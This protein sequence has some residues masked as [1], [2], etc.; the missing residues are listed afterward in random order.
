[1]W[2]MKGHEIYIVTDANQEN[3]SELDFQNTRCPMLLAKLMTRKR[4][5]LFKIHDLHSQSSHKQYLLF[6]GRKGILRASLKYEFNFSLSQISQQAPELN[7][8]VQNICIY[9]N[10]HLSYMLQIWISE[11]PNKWI[12]FQHLIFLSSLS[13]ITYWMFTHFVLQLILIRQYYWYF[14]K[15]I[16]ISK[17]LKCFEKNF[18]ERNTLF[19]TNNKKAIHACWM[20]QF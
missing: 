18:F 1:M 16:S 3:V 7:Y 12:L 20:K 17:S 14:L 19:L 6:L 10:I 4:Q 8:A 5:N 13:C 15:N 11:R 2:N 9:M